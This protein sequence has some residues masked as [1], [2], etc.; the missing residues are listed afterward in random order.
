MQRKRHRHI[1]IS[2]TISTAS[3]V[4]LLTGGEKT[5]YVFVSL[6][7][8]D[9]NLP[10]DSVR[11]ILQVADDTGANL[12]YCDYCVKNPDGSMTGHPLTAYQPG[13]VRDDFDFGPLMIFRQSPVATSASAGGYYPSPSMAFTPED[14]WRSEFSGL[15]A[16]RL[17]L[18]A[19][20]PSGIV[21]LPE[22]LYTSSE[23]DRRTSGEKQFDYVNPRNS[24][25]QKE[26]EKIFTG[27]LE[28]IGC[29]LPPASKLIDIEAG[30]FPVEAS[31]I[32]P[33]R[34]R[35]QTIAEAVESALSQETAFNFN[36]IVVDNHSSDGTTDILARLA[37][38]NPK[39]IHITPGRDDL[40][41]GGCW[42]M[43]VRDQRCGRFAV[44]L[45]SDDKYKDS[46]TL[47]KIIACFKRERCA[48]VI[49][50]YELTDFDGRPI[51]PG[52]IDHKE[53][54][55]DNGHNN[56]LRVNGLG[57]PRAF[58]TPL[59]REIGVPNVSYGEDYALGLRIS[60]DYRIGR[61][62][63]SLYLCRR[64][65]GNSDAN[66]SQV[67]INANNIYKDWLRTVELQ[68]RHKNVI[69][70]VGQWQ[71]H[72]QKNNDML[73]DFETSQLKQWPL[74][75]KNHEAL[76]DV[77][78]KT[79]PVCGFD[80]KIVFNP[81]RAI[82]AS[83]RIDAKSLAERPCFLCQEN[84]PE[85]QKGYPLVDGFELLVNPFPV[86]RHH[87]TIAST[88]HRPQLIDTVDAP[89]V[90]R[91]MSLYNAAAKLPGFVV[92]YN[93]PKCGASAPDH[94]HFQAIPGNEFFPFHKNFPYRTHRFTAASPDEYMAQMTD[95]LAGMKRSQENEGQEEPM[96]NIF[97]CQSL[98]LNL[99]SDHPI[100][101]A[102]VVPRRAHRPTCYG[103]A[104]GQM[105]ISP[106][107]VDVG[108]VIIT[109]RPGDFG[110]IDTTRLEQILRETTYFNDEN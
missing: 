80:F 76:K 38:T 68:A 71:H 78:T 58:Y 109:S 50:S 52:L 93:G 54:T 3:L 14:P 24:A 61:I 15:Y 36:V 79:V 86:F 67:K 108:G 6:E 4:G 16:V 91:L 98:G 47:A 60:R 89:G 102:L 27:Y 107:A 110:D 7:G 96:M 32:I 28:Q 63:E 26:R 101:E 51:P 62:Y 1:T 20:N 77:K 25:V 65:G 87:F 39:V 22:Y 72:Q 35:A 83:A 99:N 43:A 8:Y 97:I 55:D 10:E 74:A 9:I 106:G 84:R 29:F 69:D 59:L 64:W 11:R 56:A 41:I 40:G 73:Y 88:T 94:L 2:P 49:G 57:A 33:V 90:S 12:L 105:L 75:E 92:F 44:Q 53:W 48:M 95:I 31:V 82:S 5:D 70:E 18:A 85:V 21:H 81:A 17:Y 13:S 23:T 66:L 42:D 104:P 100:I 34:N 103:T 37:Q 45:D 30:D 46:D 19:D